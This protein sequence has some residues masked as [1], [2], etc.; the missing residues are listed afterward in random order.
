MKIAIVGPG[1]IGSLLAAYLFK[2]KVEVVLLDKCPQ[3][4]ELLNSRGISVEG[5]SGKWQAKVPVEVEPKGLENAGL[6]VLCVKSYDTKS[7]MDKIKDS[8]PESAYILTL[9]NGFGNVENI[10]EVFGPDRVLAGATNHGATLAEPG[11]IKHAGQGETIIGKVD[12]KIPVEM[13]L[14][15]ETFN[16]AGLDLKV[17]RDIKSIIWSKLI[18]NVGINALSAILRLPNGMLI[19]FEG[20]RLIMKN[21]VTEAIKVA[22]RKRV[23]LIYDDPLDKVESVCSSTAANISSML[24]DVLKKRR[25]EVDFINGFIVRQAQSMGLACNTNQMLVDLVKTVELSYE[26]EIQ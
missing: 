12:G 19:D 23:K 18:I 13:R 2:S 26:S 14:I 9:Q 4:A 22:K 20:S 7:A 5:V 3:R 11:R 24:Q 1:A 10:S 6:V 17:S 8:V 15:R 25:T 21:A 16:K